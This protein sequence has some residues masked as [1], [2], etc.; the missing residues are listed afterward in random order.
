MI[1]RMHARTA[2]VT[3]VG[4][5]NAIANDFDSFIEAMR[6]G[7]CGQRTITGFD[8]SG[9]RN[10]RACEAADFDPSPVYE[11]R[12]GRRMDRS[13]ELVLCAFDQAVAMARIDL[14]G[15]E[16]ARGAVLMGSTLGGTVT[17][18]RYYRALRVSFFI[19]W[20][21]LLAYCA[22]G[23][24]FLQGLAW[25]FAR[26][27]L[28][29]PCAFDA[30]ATHSVR[31]RFYCSG[32]A[33]CSRR[34]SLTPWILLASNRQSLGQAGPGPSRRRT[35]LGARRDLRLRR[36]RGACSRRGGGVEASDAC[37]RAARPP[38]LPPAGRLPRTSL[39]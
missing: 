8:A 18:L 13:S 19:V 10:P 5:V 39:P 14:H 12:D 35:R 24:T 32:V 22:H 16:P 34:H 30:L 2:L 15:V 21:V 11:H 17:G 33:A 4:L 37:P 27:R 23:G 9:L 1:P 36:S 20:S 3:G 25:R 7:R 6:A 28:P 26:S 38:R 31:L 29:I